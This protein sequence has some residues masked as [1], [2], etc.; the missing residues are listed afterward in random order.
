MSLRSLPR[1]A[2]F[3]GVRKLGSPEPCISKVAS[4]SVFELRGPDT[5]KFL[6]GNTTNNMLSL[7]SINSNE[8]N[9]HGMDGLYAGFL[10]PQVRFACLYQ[11]RMMADAWIHWLPSVQDPA[12]L[13]EV[14]QAIAQDLFKFISRF[15]LRSKVKIQ[16]V[17]DQWNVY[18]AWGD[19]VEHSLPRLDKTLLYR[20]VRAP[21]MGWRFLVQNQVPSQ[22]LQNLHQLPED[23]YKIHRY[24]QGVPEGSSEIIMGVS[25]P[26]ESCMDY[27]HGV[28]FHKGCYIGQELTARTHFTGLIRKRIVPV[29]L[30]STTNSSEP[31]EVNR[32]VS[33]LLPHQG[34]NITLT[35]NDMSEPSSPATSRSRS[36]S[37]GKFLNGIHNIGLALIR[38]AQLEKTQDHEGTGLQPILQVV[39]DGR[40]V[41]VHAWKPDW[42]PPQEA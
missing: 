40:P 29:L 37:A 4:R 35:Q 32:N 22:Y 1:A 11:G 17:S 28:D 34:E 3:H 33:G 19:G 14:D 9:H 20:D 36:R 10:N 24:L 5:L 25:L 7:E 42:W 2:L 8:P 27:M 30:T 18:H 26:L 13:V 6:Q 38:L 39:S 16:D 23:E 41:Q 12:V 15:K 21:R 31:M